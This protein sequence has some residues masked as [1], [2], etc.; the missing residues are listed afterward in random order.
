MAWTHTQSRIGPDGAPSGATTIALSFL[1]TVSSKALVVGTVIW[2]S[3]S[4]TCTGVVDDKG[5][6]YTRLNPQANPGAGVSGVSFYKEG[7]VNGPITLTA[8]FSASTLFRRLT[9]SEYAGIAQSAAIDGSNAQVQA[10]PGTGANIL[11]SLAATTTGNG[12]LIWGSSVDCTSTGN[13]FTAG[14]SPNAFTIRTNGL[15]SDAINQFSE[16]FR[17]PSAGSI[18]A[19]GGAD[20][21][22]HDFITHMMAFKIAQD[23][24]SSI[25][26]QNFMVDKF[27]TQQRS[28]GPK[29]RLFQM[30]AFPIITPSQP[31]SA[32]QT[33]FVV[34]KQPWRW[35]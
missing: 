11:N 5:N 3:G 9:I 16:D 25:A 22:T 8:T 4:I 34:K 32:G 17:Q 33:I 12:D 18:A 1:A 6:T 24:A 21:G 19:T 14:T 20:V 27:K 23:S 31:D 2:A 29:A 13:T 28:M 15:T 30:R 10:T 35:S 26:R 7:I